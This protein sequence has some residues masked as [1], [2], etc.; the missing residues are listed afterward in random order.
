MKQLSLAA[1]LSCSQG[2]QASS[3]GLSECRQLCCNTRAIL[4]HMLPGDQHAVRNRST[5]VEAACA[6]LAALSTHCLVTRCDMSCDHCCPLLHAHGGAPGRCSK[7]PA[8]SAC[9]ALGPVRL[10]SA[11]TAA[12]DLA[13]VELGA[14]RMRL[15]QASLNAYS[16]LG[17][18]AGS[19]FNRAY[20]QRESTTHIDREAL[21]HS[22]AE[23]GSR[24]RH[25][26]SG[27]K[28]EKGGAQNT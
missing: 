27:R 4:L 18:P 13:D 25:L 22:S 19:V 5:V 15:P 21:V 23:A 11:P 1:R 17:S 9:G 26:L 10:P 7:L 2:S 6:H 8:C 20:L 24:V 16:S 28:R 3:A 12:E 14:L